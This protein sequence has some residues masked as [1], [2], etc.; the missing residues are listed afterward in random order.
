MRTPRTSSD[1]TVPYPQAGPT[2]VGSPAVAGHILAR[3]FEDGRED[4]APVTLP[5][6]RAGT[7]T[8]HHTSRPHAPTR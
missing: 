6:D 4:A 8:H 2:R 3:P 7:A 1:P 5:D